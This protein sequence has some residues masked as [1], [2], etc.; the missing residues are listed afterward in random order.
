MPELLLLLLFYSVDPSG[1]IGA[2]VGGVIM[3]VVGCAISSKNE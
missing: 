1:A 2:V 3:F